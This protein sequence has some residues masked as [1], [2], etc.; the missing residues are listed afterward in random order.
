M[1]KENSI[2]FGSRKHHP[3]ARGVLFH[4]KAY[5]EARTEFRFN[6]HLLDGKH[7]LIAVSGGGQC[8]FLDILVFLKVESFLALISPWGTSVEKNP[9]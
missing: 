1:S 6:E 9:K 5:L 3:Q 7:R 2:A 4:L 8:L